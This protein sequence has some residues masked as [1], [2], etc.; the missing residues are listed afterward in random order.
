MDS[1]KVC[2]RDDSPT[3]GFTQACAT[4]MG[5]G[6]IHIK[7]KAV[8]FADKLKNVIVFHLLDSI[9][10]RDGEGLQK[11]LSHLRGNN[12][13]SRF[14]G[15]VSGGWHKKSCTKM[16]RDL[17]ESTQKEV[18]F[19]AI[20]GLKAIQNKFH[21]TGINVCYRK[22]DDTW[23][24]GANDNGYSIDSVDKLAKNFALIRLLAGD[25]LFF[26]DGEG[27]IHVNKAELPKEW[28]TP[29]KMDDVKAAFD[30]APIGAPFE[31]EEFYKFVPPDM[32]KKA[33]D[34]NSDIY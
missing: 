15:F 29:L 13:E 1:F 23:L 25:E 9:K 8:S 32:Q 6:I 5:G 4:C 26:G 19:S 28:L 31:V 27:E 24:L 34:F 30:V 17:V 10:Y 16:L 22:E 3:S 2:E 21:L 12:D 11:L 14:K 33:L 7:D 18:Q 20:W